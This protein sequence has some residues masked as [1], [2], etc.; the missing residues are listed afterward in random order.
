MAKKT[1]QTEQNL[2]VST[3]HIED[4]VEISINDKGSDDVTTIDVR[5]PR[6]MYV[7]IGNKVVYI[8]YTLDD[9]I[10]TSW[11]LDSEVTN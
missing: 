8:D 1:K 7:T 5:T 3:S 9:L 11:K 6:S 10:V 4:F 2:I